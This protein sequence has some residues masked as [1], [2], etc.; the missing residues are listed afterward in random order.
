[1][2]LPGKKLQ[3]S[4]KYSFP[5]SEFLAL[6][7]ILNELLEAVV[8]LGEFVSNGQNKRGVTNDSKRIRSNDSHRNTQ[9]TTT[10][11]PLNKWTS[12]LDLGNRTSGLETVVSVHNTV[13]Y[14]TLMPHKSLRDHDK[15]PKN[16]STM[17]FIYFF[18]YVREENL[19]YV[20]F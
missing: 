1:M 16:I 17:I 2:R 20:N 13:Q 7:C 19:N 9:C 11:G 15:Y 12:Q 10:Q 4:T 8:P 14:I 6:T 3:N 18:Q 5:L